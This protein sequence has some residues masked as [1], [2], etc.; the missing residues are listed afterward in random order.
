MEPNPKKSSKLYGFLVFPAICFG[1]GVW[2]LR[3][4]EW[5]LDLI[6]K[7]EKILTLPPLKLDPSLSMDDMEND[8][9]LVRTHITNGK[10]IHSGEIIV[11]PRTLDGKNG[12]HVITPFETTDGRRILV[13]RG[14]VPADKMEPQTRMEGQIE[15]VH[16]IQGILRKRNPKPSY[17]TPDNDVKRNQWY[18]MNVNEMAEACETEPIL[19]EL[20]GSRKLTNRFSLP[21]AGATLLPLNNP[22]MNY[23][24]TWFSLS[25]AMTVMSVVIIRRGSVFPKAFPTKF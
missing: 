17:F 16:E 8:D 22:H 1:L 3:R 13:N 15:E 10:Y 21:I 20:I 25:A 23:A 9:Y 19:I 7:R 4:L 2:Q 18:W 14:W 12:A 6:E 24:L 11:K 5:K